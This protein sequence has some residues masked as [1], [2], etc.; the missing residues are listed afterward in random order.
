MPPPPSRRTLSEPPLERLTPFE[1]AAVRLARRMQR[2]SWSRFWVACQRQIGARWITGLAGPLLE[3]HGLEHVA[4]TSRERPLLLAAN[5][6]SFFDL[7]VA[8]AVLYRRLPGW[9]AACFPVRGRYFYQRPGGVLVNALVA[10]WAM[11]PPFFREPGKRRFDQ[12][13]LDELGELC[14][15]GPGRLIG[16]HPEGTRNRDPDPYSFLPPQ[17]GIGRLMLQA[18]PAVI[19]VFIGG[20]PNSLGEILRRRRQRGEPIRVWFGP[21][22]DYS[23]APP[24]TA[25]SLAGLVMGAIAAQARSDQAARPLSHPA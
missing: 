3:V 22:L 16:Y 5:H 8:M 17:P 2:G 20:L 13:A 1:R 23:T 12:W 7:Y 14:R 9:R 15:E 21:A 19:P 25:A 18:T 11:Y 10:N 4:A 6:R 24:A